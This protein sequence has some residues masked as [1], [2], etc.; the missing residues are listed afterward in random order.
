MYS[1]MNKYETRLDQDLCICLLNETIPKERNRTS[2]SNLNLS[3][4]RIKP[5]FKTERNRNCGP[6]VANV[7][8]ASM[9]HKG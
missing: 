1:F 3:H 8:E 2:E 7:L 9:D 4:H 6:D 5:V